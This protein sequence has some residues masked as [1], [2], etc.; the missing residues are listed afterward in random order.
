[1]KSFQASITNLHNSFVATV[2]YVIVGTIIFGRC[3]DGDKFFP[4]TEVKK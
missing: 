2:N 4:G 1:M 3:Y